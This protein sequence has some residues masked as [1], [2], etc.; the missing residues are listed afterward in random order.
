MPKKKKH[1]NYIVENKIN[2]CTCGNEAPGDTFTWASLGG[3]MVLLCWSCTDTLHTN[4]IAKEIKQEL[5]ESK[6][7]DCTIDEGTTF[8]HNSNSRIF[9]KT[10]KD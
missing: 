2:I 7:K 9:I 10:I 1:I 3:H 8:G 6:R 4:T 5:K